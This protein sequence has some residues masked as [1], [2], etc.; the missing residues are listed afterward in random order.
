MSAEPI[1]IMRVSV[2]VA[3]N[4]AICVCLA[5]DVDL[6]GEPNLARLVGNLAATDCTTVYIDLHG[7]TFGGSSLINFLFGV[8]SSLPSHTTMT[9]CR[10]GAMVTQLI[11]LMGVLDVANIRRDLP[12][13][14]PAALA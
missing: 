14:W 7:I 4:H 13:D 10:P 6:I 8:A 12:A 3:A 1:N 9:L 2:A 5:G 11:G